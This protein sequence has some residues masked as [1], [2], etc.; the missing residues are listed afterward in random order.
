MKRLTDTWR[1]SPTQSPHRTRIGWL[2]ATFVSLCLLPA[3]PAQALEGDTVRPFVEA[4]LG[5]DTNLFRFADD[6][7]ARASSL[8]DPIESIVFQRYGAG[9]DV[10]W[11]QGRQQVTGRLGANQTSFNRYSNLL[12][13]SGYNLNGEWKWQ[14]GN[15]WSGI[16]RAGREYAQQPYTDRFTGVIRNN[17]R[18][19]K[20]HAFQAEYWFHTDWRAS[21][22][23]DTFDREYDEVAQS[24]DN[25]RRR[26][27]TLGLYTR[28]NT[29]E[30]LGVEYIDS[31]NEYY[32]RPVLPNLDNESDE[33]A[34]RLVGSWAAS[35]KTTVFGHLGYAKRD[36]PNVDTQGFNGLEWRLG[37]RWL[38]TGKSLVESIVQRDLGES[39]D[40]GVNFRRIDSATVNA[41]WLALPKTRLAGRL[42]YARDKFDGTSRK[43]DVLSATLSASYEAWTGGEVS[44]GWE[45]SRRDSTFA[46]QEYR[47]DTL[48][49]S[50]NLRF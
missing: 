44:L 9:V 40:P 27:I 49:L 18:T 17:L 41:T 20:T 30:R 3:M 6:A 36:Y 13:Y 14:L 10:D 5:Y 2:R 38:P 37:A 50:A 11:K 25:F 15:R 1:P 35:G 29:M 7:E 48:F 47:A 43:D 19:D 26:T 31:R 42:R 16:L 28:G 8:G 4:V 33:Q 21:A 12:D 45:H 46:T 34:V 22:R 39:D 32:D 24:F 23:I